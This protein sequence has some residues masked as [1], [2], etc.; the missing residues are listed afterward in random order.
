MSERASMRRRSFEAGGKRYVAILSGLS[1]IT[2]G[3][4][5]SLPSAG[6]AQS[7]HAV[8]VRAVELARRE[9]G[10]GARICSLHFICSAERVRRTSARRKSMID[11]IGFPVSDYARSKAF[12]E[13]THW[14]RSATR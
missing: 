4:I 5:S 3:N 9:S 10:Q 7:D 1:Q 6:A 12:Y 8:R 2:R 14:R 13:S 11:H